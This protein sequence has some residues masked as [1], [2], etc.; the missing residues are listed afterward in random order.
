MGYRL[1]K[2]PHELFQEM[3]EGRVVVKG[4]PE[5]AKLENYSMHQFDHET[6]LKY[7]H[8]SWDGPKKGD[9]IP[10]IDIRYERC[11]TEAAP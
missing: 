6:V 2:L 4:L 11:Q 8:S 7:S 3:L 1:A 5:G 9:L 10:F